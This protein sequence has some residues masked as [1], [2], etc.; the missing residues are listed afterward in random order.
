MRIFFDA[1]VLNREHH[2]GIFEYARF[3]L[4]K[5]LKKNPNHDYSVF[6]NSFRSSSFAEKMFGNLK[7][8]SLVNYHFPNR[9]FDFLNFAFSSPKIDSLVRADIFYSPHLDIM[10]FKN[11]VKHILTV[12]DL[13]FIHHPDFFSL[14]RQFWHLRQNYEKQIKEAGCVIT[15]SYFTAEDIAAN[16]HISPDKIK[17]I[18]SGVNPAYKVLSVDNSELIAFKWRSKINDPF[19]LY[20]G[21][22]EPRKNI[23]GIIKA[24]NIL[25]RKAV[26]NDLKLVIVGPKG[27]LYN[28]IFREAS[29]SPW[30]HSI[31]FWGEAPENEMLYLYNLASVFI[32]PSFFEG[33][34]FPPLEA[35]ACGLPVVSSNRS[36]IP[37]ILGDSALLADPWRINE[38]ALGIEAVLTDSSLRKILR[39]KGLENIKRF[40]W[41]YTA[42]KLTKVFEN[43]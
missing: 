30:K 39:E 20:T 3:L 38:L 11:P 8:V 12:H 17:T 6:V 29:A 42:Q 9:I 31:N 23:T 43:L 22:L 5:I 24:F 16:F 35:Q 2:S 33:F 40:K 27:W 32:Y 36:S 37:E 10:S 4:T 26:F 21:A 18:Y 25:K 7:N 15:P 41:E 34:G 19:L 13:S 1:R 14:Q 28:N